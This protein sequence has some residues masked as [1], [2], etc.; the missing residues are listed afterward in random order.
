MK[1]I[2]GPL[3]AL[4]VIGF[5]LTNRWFLYDQWRMLGYQPPAAVAKMAYDAKFTPS[6]LNV[7]YVNHPELSNKADFAKKCPA[8]SEKT[9][10]LGCYHGNQRA[11]YVLDVNA[12][13]LEGIEEV[14]AA[15]E[16]L[17]AQY[18]RL[19]S[20]ERKKIDA[21]LQ[22]VYDSL[23]DQGVK[24]TVDAYR[25]SEPDALLNE[26][27]SIFPTQLANLP[28]A[29]ETY[30]KRYFQDRQA[31]AA[32][33]AKYND[34]FVSRENKVKQADAQLAAW[35][36]EMDTLEADLRQQ[37][38]ALNRQRLSM[39][40]LRASG[41]VGAYNAQVDSYNFQVSAYNN[42]VARLKQIINDYNDLV[43]TRNNIALEEQALVK[44]ISSAS[45]PAAQ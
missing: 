10:V 13:E 17:H 8:G 14:T 25:K 41:S 12:P 24:D 29:L 33:F 27:H 1:K 9:A 45:V 30:Y 37:Q 11:I 5:L 19:S 22:A 2:L 40:Q 21:Q 16:L 6:A 18:D 42:G 34:A 3:L 32:T 44:A 26:M 38:T 4:G 39:Q 31:L 23:T 20:R 43:A 15:H 36:A 7:F 28:P 35:K